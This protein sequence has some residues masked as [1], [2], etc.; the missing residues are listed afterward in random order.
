MPIRPQKSWSCTL[1]LPKS[2][3]PARPSITDQVDYLKRCTDDLYKWQS[4]ERS[5]DP[6]FL[7]HDGPPYANGE[8][9]IGHAL[10]KILKDIICRRQIQKG[11]RVIYVPGWDCHGLPIELKALERQRVSDKSGDAVYDSIKIRKIARELAS[12]TVKSQMKNFREWGIMA[13]WAQAWK[14]MDKPY[15]INQLRIFQSMVKKGLIFRRFKPVYW[16]PSSQTALAEAE[17][18]YKIDHCSTAAYVKFPIVTI[19]EALEKTLPLGA[20]LYAV[21]WTT[22]PWT[23]PANRAIAIHSEL[24]YS[25]V[26]HDSEFLIIAKDR[27]E[28][29]TK[30]LSKE[31]TEIFRDCILG[32]DLKGAQYTHIFGGSTFYPII[33]AEFVSADSGS[34]LVH[35]APGH[36]QDD[37]EI[38]TR[39]GIEAAAPVND[40]GCFTADAFPQNPSTLEGISV[41]DG[42]GAKVLELLGNHVVFTHTYKHKYPYDWRTKLPVIIRATEQWFADVGNIKDE[43]I[44]NLKTVFF[45]PESG[46]SRLE[47]FVKGRNE[48][49]ISR[50]RAWGVPIPALYKENGTAILTTE[51]IEHII[52]VIHKRGIDAWWTD[53]PEEPS[54]IPPYLNGNL[55]RGKDTMDVWFDS[56]SS[57][58][59]MNG[60]ADVYLEGTDQHR[61]WFQSS[62]LTY[63]GGSGRKEAPFK[64][65]ITHGFVLDQAGKKMSKSIGNVISPNQI[66]DGSLLPPKVKKKKG[67]SSVSQALGVDALR[68][69]VASCDFTRD[70]VIGESVLKSNHSALLK[71]RMILKMLLGSMHCPGEN[72]II[73]TLDQIALTHLQ[74]VMAEVNSSYDKFEFYQAVKAINKWVNTELSS[75]YLEAI[76]DR[77]YCGDGGSVLDKIFNGLLK[78]L[79]PIT[80]LLVEEAWSHRP[81]W[82]KARGD[83]HPFH[84]TPQKPFTIDHDLNRLPFIISDI[85]W[86]MNAAGAIRAAQEQARAQKLIGSSLESSVILELPTSGAAI[87]SR[88]I[89][90]LES[91]FVVSSV[92]LGV[93]PA[94][95]WKFSSN[96]DIPEGRATAWIT[97]PKHEKCP[98]C[99]RYVAPAQDQLC[100]RCEEFVANFPTTHS[101]TRPD[102]GLS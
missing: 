93:E 90:D 16:S 78:M 4:R 37:Y 21:T 25:I 72:F 1:R 102:I 99:W 3:F 86:L 49:C 32:R 53:S 6:S 39:L 48:W 29:V 35:V 15:E 14:T 55:R 52:S 31:P 10:N 36:G 46:R 41:L 80:P 47:S 11:K 73:T 71:F 57:W 23:L 13:D 51:S 100:R 38:C 88:Y 45:I 34:G 84:M 17:L 79:T 64:T 59:Q 91:I 87:F 76:K 22:T 83:P 97:A 54:W 63:V 8:L 82:M 66:I 43:A 58:N 19:P 30:L 20:K 40:L 50:Q 65:L 56:G 2:S 60:R 81:E 26:N 24:E 5:S 75:F 28:E 94:D 77:L 42:G 96:F 27:I 9:H 61:G 67:G 92:A 69:W 101:M 95:E 7:L 98:R 74:L 89:A 62:L 18:E 33:E 68:L 70:V 44:K 12:E 85:P